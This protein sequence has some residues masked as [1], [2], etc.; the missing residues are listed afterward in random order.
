MAK[1]SKKLNSILRIAVA[2]PLHRIF[3]YLPP[4]DTEANTLSAGVRIRVPFGHR[5]KV[6]VLIEVTKHSELQPEN[7]KQALE[8]IDTEPLLSATDMALLQWISGYYHHPLGDVVV[9]AMP[10]L[11]RQGKP[12]RISSQKLYRLSETGSTLNPED[13]Q[14]ARIQQSLIIKL[15]NQSLPVNAKQLNMWHKTWRPAM[16]ALIEKG[17]IEVVNDIDV[18]PITHSNVNT[19]VLQA[20]EE[21]QHAIAMVADSLKGF[22][23]HLL[24]GV[25][26]S[27]KTEVYM[28]LI[29]QVIEQGKQ[30]LVLVPEIS[31]TPQL[32][33]RF[34]QRF[35]VAVEVSHSGLTDL[36]RCNIWL[37]AQQGHCPIV[38]GTRSALMMPMPHLGLI[39]ID[40][41]H[42]S[43]FKQQ[44]GLR[45]SAR[46]VAVV[47]AKKLNIPILMG[48]ATPSLESFYNAQEGR[49]QWL[50]L[51]KR[52]GAASEPVL[53][54]LDIRN[55]LL[56]DGL[57]DILLQE[58]HQVLSKGEQ[59]L[60][61]LNRRG[62][63]P[64]LMCHGCG[65]VAQCRCCDAN[66]VV[67]QQDKV[68]R[69]H[70]CGHQQVLPRQC[71]ACHTPNL[72]AL[73]L[74]TERIEQVLQQHFPSQTIIRI[75]RDTTRRKGELE[76]GL[77]LI[78]NGQANIILGTQMLAKGHHFPNVTL[79][80]ILDVD[81]GLFSI[82]FH[83]AEKMAQMIVQVSGRAGRS[84]KPG[85][86]I[87]Q[88]RQP[89]HPLLLTLIRQGYRQFAQQTLQER[90]LAGLPPYSYQALFRVLAVDQQLAIDFLEQ[91]STLAQNNIVKDIEIMGPVPAPMIRRAGRYRYQLLIQARKRASLHAL[92]DLLVADIAKLKS[93]KKVRWS[94]DVDPVDL[95]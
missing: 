13:L 4:T 1:S 44:E 26:G 84:E 70:H 60:L 59:A 67:H 28:Q 39:I 58:I 30:V 18:P 55:K 53:R 27:G 65:W 93:S 75:D 11:L 90:S 32:E 36:Q 94:L 52:A 31:L 40:E 2:V 42:D 83:A 14:R 50:H 45:F 68:L 3:D 62:F 91:V 23:A 15:Q 80:G 12:A 86:V 56:H 21:Q 24:E 48:T 81:S 61:F 41:E 34:K 8:I 17:L 5:E 82:D 25:T 51:S 88:T 92:L 76:K 9:S 57:S 29:S 73:G 43:S 74:G 16:A 69:C 66:L 10:V 6:G 87:M 35:S 95:Y 89:E 77:E 7:L 20:N 22:A 64:A 49:Y 33:S 19:H 47:R 72:L 54:L 63:A 71:P 78:N 46:D 37:K 85:Q 38:V 79:V